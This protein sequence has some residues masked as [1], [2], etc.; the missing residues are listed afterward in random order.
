MWGFSFDFLPC[1]EWWLVRGLFVSPEEEGGGLKLLLKV[2]SH[3]K[4][5]PTVL[6]VLDVLSAVNHYRHG[7]LK[8]MVY[9][10]AAATL[11]YC[12]TY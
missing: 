6:I 3:P 10:L 11:S 8:Q 9:W 4:T 1:T 7:N 5:F 2:L 12:V